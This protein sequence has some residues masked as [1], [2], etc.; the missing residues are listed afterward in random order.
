ML[1]LAVLW[2]AMIAGPEMEAEMWTVLKTTGGL[3][4]DSV[5]AIQEL[6]LN[7]MKPAVTTE[8][9]A[10]LRKRFALKKE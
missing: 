10:D 8:Q 6:Y 9:L 7:Q 1:A 5:Q 2:M 3:D 4:D